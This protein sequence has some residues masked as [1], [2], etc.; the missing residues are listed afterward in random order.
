MSL[1]VTLSFTVFNLGDK[2][3]LRLSN[4]H[5]LNNISLPVLSIFNAP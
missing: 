5:A 1:K 4:L 2:T 3:S